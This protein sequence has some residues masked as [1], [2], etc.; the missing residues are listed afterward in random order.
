M[1]CSWL[2]QDGPIRTVIS[3]FQRQH[4]KE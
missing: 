4:G 2:V 3:E 1:I